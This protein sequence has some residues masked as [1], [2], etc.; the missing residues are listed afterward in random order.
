MRSMR[1]CGCCLKRHVEAAADQCIDAAALTGCLS[2]T[3]ATMSF[4]YT[5][6]PQVTIASPLLGPEEQG[7]T[8]TI[9]GQDFVGTTH[10]ACRVGNNTSPATV[11]SSTEAVC[12][13]LPI[14]RRRISAQLQD[15]FNDTD[16]VPSGRSAKSRSGLVDVAFG[17]D[18]QFF[19]E[20]VGN[21]T[22]YVSPSMFWIFPPNAP[23]SDSNTVIRVNGSGFRLNLTGAASAFVH[24]PRCKFG[25][26]IGAA[27]VVSDSM[28]LCQARNAG[29]GEAVAVAVALN[30]I[31]FEFHNSAFFLWLAPAPAVQTILVSSAL[32]QVIVSFADPTDRLV[33]SQQVL[34]LFSLALSP[35]ISNVHRGSFRTTN[36]TAGCG[37]AS[38]LCPVLYEAPLLSGSFQVSAS[39]S[40]KSS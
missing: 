2:L 23:L 18:G 21:Y 27:T 1:S 31:D 10:S 28:M 40:F 14:R 30:G 26:E 39:L 22:Y 38:T 3:D 24:T 9:R 12:S 32:S 19:S 15:W 33:T 20:V 37:D 35:L 11:I 29:L 34:G 13:A 7:S 5:V 36:G 25:S 8:I 4:L 6:L 17:V 16:P